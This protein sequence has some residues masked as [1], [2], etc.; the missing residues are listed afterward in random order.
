MEHILPLVIK[1]LRYIGNEVGSAHKQWD[2][3]KLKFAICYPDLYE[4]G[5][6]Y[7]GLR[8]LYHLLNRIDD[9]LC[10]R[11]F[12]PAID[13]E[14]LFKQNNIPLFS[15]ESHTPLKEFD[16]IGFSLQYELTYTNVLNILQLAGI[17]IHRAHR[18]HT[19]P[20]ILA[21]GTCTLN[22][23]PIAPFFDC[24]F[25]G[26]AEPILPK[27]VEIV[28][29]KH[30]LSRDELLQELAKLPGIYVPDISKYT[31]RLI[32]QDLT[33]DIFPAPWI[34]PFIKTTQD[35][36][37]VE[38]AR[39]C[40]RGCRFCQPGFTTRPYRER[41][42]TQIMQIVETGVKQTGYTN[43]SLLSLSASDHSQ[44]I[45]I[46]KRIKKLNL[47]ISL[48]SML[49]NSLTSELVTLIGKGGITLAPEAG[50]D[51]LKQRINKPI[52]NSQVL[53][54]CEL[55][56]SHGFTHIKLYYIIGLPDENEEDIDGIIDLTLQIARIMKGKQ[57]NVTI[58]PFIPK[59]HTPFQWAKQQTPQL[60]AQKIEY[61]KSKL[62]KHNIKIKHN[63][64][65]SFFIEGICARGDYKIAQVIEQARKAGA[66]FDAWNDQFNLTYWEQAFEKVGINPYDYL[67]CNTP[68]PWEMIDIGV[69]K[70]VLI[71]EYKKETQTLDCRIQ[72]CYNCGTCELP[73]PIPISPAVVPTSQLQYGR[74]KTYKP[75][76]H[77]KL[78]FRVKFEKTEPLRF[79]GHLD[80]VRAIIRGI[81]RSNIP[82]AYS[83][84]FTKRPKLSFSPPL[85]FGVTSKEEYFDMQLNSPPPSEIK[86][87]LN[88]NLP[89]GIKVLEV[90]TLLEQ[91]FSLASLTH[92]KYKIENINVS[93]QRIQEFIAKNEILLH[94]I[95]IRPYIINIEKKEDSILLLMKLSKVKPCWIIEYLLQITE[96]QAIQFKIQRTEYC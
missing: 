68:L 42:V 8:I 29:H 2:K 74:F 73:N 84:G 79:L 45:E 21:G 38:I 5:M 37:V 28:K 35:T 47:N 7:L 59:P 55:V 23:A 65:Y 30:T 22:P 25:I 6:S 71:Q 1:P 20:L 64:L 27:F 89:N 81:V 54:S 33:N 85:P 96:S 3:T 4:I 78:K 90:T 62:R 52:T 48:P 87:L 56:A 18:K 44:L 53:N 76:Q 92:C 34:V 57:I 69:K 58:S 19:D 91:S 67:H 24:M 95:N 46:I 49:G 11:V 63:N 70:E 40:S 93:D 36:F 82:I 9:T 83:E 15:M 80:L 94:Q 39:G 77:Q 60:L 16:C 66:K 86:L 13:A 41:E 75:L 51:R 50:T 88:Q 14:N 32:C 61:I 31:K 43:I 12:A 10:E 17:P 26:E 72:G